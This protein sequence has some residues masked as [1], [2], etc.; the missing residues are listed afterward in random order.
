MKAIILAAGRGERMLPLTEHTPKPLL[1]VAGQPLIAHHLQRLA[2]AG[3]GEVVINLSHLGDQ[4]RAALGDGSAF[5][6]RI[7]YSQEPQPALETGG[8]IVNALPLLGAGQFLVINGDVWCDYPWHRLRQIKTET[9]HLLLV[10]NPAHHPAGDFALR[11]LRVAPVDEANTSLTYAGI[12]V[13]HPRFFG[14]APAG[15]AFPLGPLLHQAAAAGQLTGEHYRGQWL[16]VGTV[17]RLE[18]LRRRL[19]G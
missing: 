6:L 11:G 19:G 12:G 18:A 10:D 15:E 16:D 5:G 7:L 8:G 4:I 3:F 14:A 9:A 17:E 2:G 1:A 13:F